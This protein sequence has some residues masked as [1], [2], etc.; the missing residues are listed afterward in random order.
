M[1]NR[2]AIWERVANV[3]DPSTHIAKET[4]ASQAAGFARKL[5]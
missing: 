1:F 4:A 5:Q 3:H 2:G